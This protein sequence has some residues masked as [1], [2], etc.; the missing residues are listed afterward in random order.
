MAI[1]REF[2]KTAE[3]DE[4]DSCGDRV[5]KNWHR[6]RV[7]SLDSTLITKGI[8]YRPGDGISNLS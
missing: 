3:G 4:Q 7:T 8:S 2:A 5:K 6:P 1:E